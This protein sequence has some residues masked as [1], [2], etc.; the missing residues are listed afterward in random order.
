MADEYPRLTRRDRSEEDP[1]MIGLWKVGRTIGKG[2]SGRVRIARHV[3]TRQF[4]AVKIVSKSTLANKHTRTGQH[5]LLNI[6]REI[7]IMKLIDHPHV[8][9]LY[10]VWETSSDLYLILEYIE[11]GELFDYLCSNGP[12]ST[13]EALGYFQQ[14]IFA[15][16]YCHRFNI[17]HRDL[18]PENLLMDKEKNIK[19][20]D[21]GM[22]AWQA[23][24]KDGLLQTACGSPHYAA[25]EII[26]GKEYDG[27][28]SDIWSCGIILFALLV[29]HLPFDDEDLVS[30]LEKVRLAQYAVP[31][32][33]DPMAKDLISKMLKKNVEER[34]TIPAIL[35]HPF[36]LSQKPKV[37]KTDTPDLDVMSRP[38][39]AEDIDKDILANL[40]TLWHGI[41]DEDIIECLTND[42]PNWQKGVYHL[43]IAYRYKHVEDYDEEEEI[44]AQARKKKSEK[45]TA[46]ECVKR[47]TL[48]LDHSLSML[49]P[50]AD[51]PTPRRA[52]RPLFD[53]SPEQ[54]NTLQ[55]SLG[56]SRRMSSPP[57]PNSRPHSVLTVPSKLDDE[58]MYE[59]FQEIV[60]RLNTMELSTNTATPPVQ[61]Q[62]RPE[63]VEQLPSLNEMELLWKPNGTSQDDPP[64]VGTIVPDNE[65][66][67]TTQFMEPDK[68][69]RLPG[70]LRKKSS[71]TRNHTV[72]KRPTPRV[73]IIEPSP[74]R[75]LRR[76]QSFTTSIFSPALLGR[77]HSFP[78]MPRKRR[79]SNVFRSRPASY[80]LLSTRNVFTSREECRRVLLRLGIR[81]NLTHTE[82]AGVLECKFDGVENP[83]GI[84]PVLK[85]VHFRV[86]VQQPT[87]PQALAGYQVAL[88]FIQKQGASSSFQTICHSVRRMWELDV[89]RAPN[90][91]TDEH[92]VIS[93]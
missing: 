84:L 11:G 55:I 71:L 57:G 81:V 82:E 79:L 19:I 56:P 47:T 51:P 83:R 58:N 6:E 74:P 65:V 24:A 88:R 8:M 41:P 54:V 12:L 25:P 70:I 77:S 53:E 87:T 23:R 86:E 35:E 16:D 92:E 5:M 3:K 76:K 73:Q 63:Q 9:R 43:L 30:L 59:F 38:V 78:S 21:F 4:A 31:P 75:R 1:K 80:E 93:S 7:V 15:V 49:P 36:F 32:G 45:N 2:S 44:I 48:D 64:A 85:F 62:E 34:I 40:R 67:R 22:A 17:A 60:E 13:S 72:P 14:I 33:I 52:V 68:P 69:K 89:P 39:S 46:Q 61:T 42:R 26:M 10:D 91:P 37:A 90:T 66:W 20:A 50:R 29:G 28:F 18:K 27:R